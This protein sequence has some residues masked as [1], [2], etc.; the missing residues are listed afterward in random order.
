MF[1]S[2]IQSLH[3]DMASCCIAL[4][5]LHPQSMHSCMGCAFDVCDRNPTFC[6]TM[7]LT[8]CGFSLIAARFDALLTEPTQYFCR[9]CLGSNQVGKTT[10]CSVAHYSFPVLSFRFLFCMSFSCMPAGNLEQSERDILTLRSQ[11]GRFDERIAMMQH[12]LEV[13]STPHLILTCIKCHSQ[14]ICG[15]VTAVYLTHCS[16]GE[17]RMLHTHATAAFLS[18]CPDIVHCTPPQHPKVASCNVCPLVIGRQRMTRCRTS[19]YS[20]GLA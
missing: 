14:S 10:C 20:Q 15:T 5:V 6:N 3:F 1:S 12:L 19:I 9:L 7:S 8:F 2:P 18:R 16:G 11:Q 4:L 13:S 17:E